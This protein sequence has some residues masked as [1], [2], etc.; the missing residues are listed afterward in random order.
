[1][2]VLI[3]ANDILEVK[4][5][6]KDATQ[7]AV[8]VWH[9]F[10]S[11]ITG[12]SLTD[13]QVCTALSAQVAPLYKALQSVG[14]SYLGLRLQRIR[15]GT[16]PAAVISTSGTG[17]GTAAGGP[18]PSMASILLSKRTNL[19]GRANRGRLYL[20]FISDLF[21]SGTATV[22]AGGVTAATNW[23]NAMFATIT[24]TIGGDAVTLQP[25]INNRDP[26]GTVFMTSVAIR[27]N[28]ATQRRR[29][30][31]NKGDSFGP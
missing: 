1:M 14:S 16:V 17:A 10:V 12:A 7:Q 26:A 19:A 13:Q 2:A 29:S 31:I 21:L 18:L 3:A 27:D 25:V 11:G 22:T 9:Y 23:S 24:V 4:G 8:N 6:N 15:P 5:F 20:P 30:L 28:F